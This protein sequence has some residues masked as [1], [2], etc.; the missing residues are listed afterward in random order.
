MPIMQQDFIALILMITGL[1]LIGFRRRL[2]E[3]VN[4][5]WQPKIISAERLILAIGMILFLLGAIAMISDRPLY[6]P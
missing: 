1:L 4:K 3:R 2:G 6:V 5:V